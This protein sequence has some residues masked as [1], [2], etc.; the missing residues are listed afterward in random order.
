MSQMF[1][2][3]LAEFV[4]SID[5][6]DEE[7]FKD[8]LKLIQ[9]YVNE[10]LNVTY[11]SV[12]DKTRINEHQG[13]KTIWSTREEGPSYAVDKESGYTS[14]SAYTFGENKPLWVVSQSQKP[15]Q[16]A[17]DIK[18]MW[19]GAKDLPPYRTWGQ[20]DVRTS[21]MYPLTKE[22]Y[23]I[24]VVEFATEKYVEPTPASLDEVRQLAT[25]IQ[26]AYQ[27]Y[28]VRRTQRDNTKSALHLLEQALRAGSWTRL[29]LPQMFV[30]YPGDER[31][32]PGTRDEHE[33][34]IAAI[35]KV[36]GGFAGSLTAIFWEDKTEAGNINEQVIRDICNSDFGLCYFSE[37][38]KQGQYQDNANV[39][40]EAGMMQ[41]LAFSPNAL[42]R[43]WIP[44]R[45]NA[46]P[47]IPFDI[48]AE[49]MLWVNRVDG[50]LDEAAFAEALR[51]RVKEL[52]GTPE[53]KESVDKVTFTE[54]LR[55]RVD[56]LVEPLKS[57]E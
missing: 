17:D 46:S 2:E 9:T 21:V 29:A 50:K 45:E 23:P 27:M 18:D 32:D 24:G 37:P 4:F 16:K 22:T 55:Q 56:A 51:R 35:R 44:V 30:A 14:H 13:L 48:A 10:H 49:R 52:V 6:L 20:E 19:S 47:D 41:A 8:L 33:V 40:F 34:V 28:E 42:L 31:L 5:I 38:A 12:L 54:A 7:T 1:S 43:A 53:R 25:V 26:R 3:R 11:F 39:L 57:K 36:V 15:L